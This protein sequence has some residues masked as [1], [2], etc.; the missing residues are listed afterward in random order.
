M[1]LKIAKGGIQLGTWNRRL[2][3]HTN[4]VL[5]LHEVHYD[6]NGIARLWSKDGATVGGE[7][8]TDIFACLVRMKQAATTPILAIRKDHHGKEILVEEASGRRAH[9]TPVSN[10]PTKKHR[11]LQQLSTVITREL[12]LARRKT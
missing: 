11:K 4:S 8:L 1:K 9:N 2:I 5:I 3:R 10:L 12:T 7:T 6:K